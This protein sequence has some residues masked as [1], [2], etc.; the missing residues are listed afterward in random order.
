MTITQKFGTKTFFTQKN[1]SKSSYLS[2]LFRIRKKKNKKLFSHKKCILLNICV[3]VTLF[4]LL[5][6]LKFLKF[7]CEKDLKKLL[8]KINFH[9]KNETK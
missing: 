4:F 2:F 5:L 9:I 3:I 7:F 6:S 8:K 1:L